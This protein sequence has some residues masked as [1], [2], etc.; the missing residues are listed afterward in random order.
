MVL[1]APCVERT[2]SVGGIANELPSASHFATLSHR[3]SG[4]HH[5]RG[6]RT[7]VHCIQVGRVM[8]TEQEDAFRIDTVE[9]L[10]EALQFLPMDMPVR[11]MDGNGEA[12]ELAY[13]LW[14]EKVDGKVTKE[15]VVIM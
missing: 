11:S 8:T 15:Y 5:L 1:Y 12:K 3:G 10:L 9:D 2:P 6:I 4:A 7:R 13:A 14:I